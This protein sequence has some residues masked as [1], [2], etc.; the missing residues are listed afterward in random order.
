MGDVNAC[1]EAYPNHYV[2][3]VAY[4]S[5]PR[6][7][8]S[9]LSFIVNRPAH[10]P[11]FRLERQDVADRRMRYT[12]IPYAHEDP[13]GRVTRTAVTSGRP[14]SAGV[15]AAMPAATRRSGDGTARPP[16]AGSPRRATAEPE[17]R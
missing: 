5:F 11:G 9:A 12:V 10:E 16:P 17:T 6:A 13:P 3:V 14:R 1:R 8:T 7:Q 2:K 4:D 15:Q